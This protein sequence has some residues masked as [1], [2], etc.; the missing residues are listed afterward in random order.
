MTGTTSERRWDSRILGPKPTVRP[1][2]CENVAIEESKETARML[3]RY[4]DYICR[5]F[6]I[7]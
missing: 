3:F 1:D 4:S 5:Y 7:E 6:Q 2:E